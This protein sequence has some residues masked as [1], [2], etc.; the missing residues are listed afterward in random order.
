[1]RH[2]H[3]GDVAVL[4][5][6]DA[7][8]ESSDGAGMK[9]GALHRLKEKPAGT[10]RALFGDASVTAVV[11]GMTRGGNKAEIRSALVGSLE[12]GEIAEGRK[13]GSQ[14]CYDQAAQRFA[15]CITNKPL[16]PFPYQA[17]PPPSRPRPTPRP[18]RPK[19]PL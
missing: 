15:A 4:L 8:E 13:L 19:R 16:P 9:R 7:A 18:I 2:G 11:A 1:M 14:S 17:P 10:A 3:D 5:F 6:C 12:T